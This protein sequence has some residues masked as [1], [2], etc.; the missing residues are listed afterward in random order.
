MDSPREPNI[1]FAE[2]ALYRREFTNEST[3]KGWSLL[4]LDIIWLRMFCVTVSG[5]R[6]VELVVYESDIKIV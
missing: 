4:I 6:E 5:C 3:F 1:S 2:F